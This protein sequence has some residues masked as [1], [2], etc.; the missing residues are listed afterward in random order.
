[1]TYVHVTDDSAFAVLR[2]QNAQIVL[3]RC[4]ED[5]FEIDVHRIGMLF[6]LFG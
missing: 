6:I 1:M 3:L 5:M 4:Y 2:G